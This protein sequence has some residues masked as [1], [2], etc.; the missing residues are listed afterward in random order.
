MKKILFL[1]LLS[2]FFYNH[3]NA[4]GIPLPYCSDCQYFV[5]V[6]DLPDSSRFYSEEYKAYVDLGYVYNQLWAL[7]LPLWNTN[8]KYC[9]LIEGQDI[10][11]DLSEEELK[12]IELEQGYSLSANPI[13]FWD[14]MGGK[15]IVL[16]IIGF[17]IWGQIKPKKQNTNK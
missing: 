4:K 11:F 15:L 5:T 17:F 16:F 1:T 3:V 13:P 12:E 9:L 10:Y 2:L 7:W 6:E 8:G 14:K